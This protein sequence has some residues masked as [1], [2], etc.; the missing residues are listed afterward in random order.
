MMLEM[1]KKWLPIKTGIES[2]GYQAALK[3]LAEALW[4]NE[5]MRPNLELLPH[6]TTH[7]KEARIRGGVRFFPDGKAY[8]H[9][10]NVYFLEEYCTFPRG[11]TKDVLDC[12]TWNMTMMVPPAADTDYA[13]E[14]R[15]DDEYFQ[16]LHPVVGI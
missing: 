8:I 9:K 16:S 4:R 11:K 3:P 7:T 15:A 10:S 2:F 1:H 12:W 6:D 13:E 14:Q 5:P